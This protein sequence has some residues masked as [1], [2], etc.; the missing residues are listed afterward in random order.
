MN[1]SSKKILNKMAELVDKAKHTDSG[2]KLNGYVTAIQAL[3]DV[4]LE[5][6]EGAETNAAADYASIQ[7]PRALSQPIQPNAAASQQAVITSMP[8]ANPVK[9]DDANGDSLFD[10]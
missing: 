10:F 1:I 3:C 4:L 8:P 2:E 9:M 7:Q 5:E 6:K